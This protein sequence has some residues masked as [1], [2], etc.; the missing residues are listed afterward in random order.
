VSYFL[1]AGV[2]IRTAPAEGPVRSCPA[3]WATIGPERSRRCVAKRNQGFPRFGKR[4]GL[5]LLHLVCGFPALISKARS[6]TWKPPDYYFLVAAGPAAAA[7]IR[8]IAA[9]AAQTP[10]TQPRVVR[11]RGSRHVADHFWSRI[12][13]STSVLRPSIAGRIEGAR[14]RTPREGRCGR[15]RSG[16][17][18]LGE[19]HRGCTGPRISN[20]AF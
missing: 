5:S 18:D 13:T 17:R 8:T 6:C 19:P 2:R 16:I 4:G 20:S 7:R 9:T 14:R 12:I 11:A 1:G 3:R 15:L 10:E